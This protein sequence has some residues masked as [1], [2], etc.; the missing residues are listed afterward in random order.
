MV[1][2]YQNNQEKVNA[3]KSAIAL[4]ERWLKAIHIGATKEDMEKMGLKTPNVVA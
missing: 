4:R 3:M 2:K 1:K